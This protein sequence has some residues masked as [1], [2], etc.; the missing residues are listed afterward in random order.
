MYLKTKAEEGKGRG[1]ARGAEREGEWLRNVAAIVQEITARQYI[2][3]LLLLTMLG[4]AQVCERARKTAGRRAQAKAW[5]QVESHPHLLDEGC[6][7]H[8]VEGVDSG[9]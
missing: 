2:D 1:R 8:V 5:G 4:K 9:T 3:A 6:V 7:C